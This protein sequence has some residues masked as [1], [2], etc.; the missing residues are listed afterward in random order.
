MLNFNKT[1]MKYKH[2][3]LLSGFLLLCGCGKYLDIVPDGTPTLEHA[4]ADRTR[5]KEFLAT[6]YRYLPDPT[7]C[8]TYPGYAGN[9]FVWN[10][11]QPYDTRFDEQEMTL[12][13]RGRQ[14]SS[15]PYLNFWGGGGGKKVVNLFEGIR[16]CN[17][18]LE[19]IDRPYD[20][21][22]G[23][24]AQWI[25]EV[26]FLKAYYHYFLLQLYGPIPLIKEN[27]PVDS[28]PE[29]VRVF[30]DPF[31]DCVE[32][33][34]QLLDEAA[35]DLPPT[36]GNE[37]EEMGRITSPIAL[38]LKT[39]VLALAASDLFNGNPDFAMCIDKQGR[40]LFPTEKDPDKWKLVAESAKEAIELAESQGNIK[41]YESK[42]ISQMPDQ[43]RLLLTLRGV[44][45]EN[46]NEEII[47]GTT[48]RFD[49]NNKGD[50]MGMGY[51]WY[52]LARECL[53]NLYSYDLQLFLSECGVPM[54]IAEL[55][56]TDKGI[57]IEN[58]PDWIGK[59]VN[60]LMAATAKDKYIIKEGEQ[61]ARFNFNR[62]PR[63][64]A[65]LAFDSSIFQMEV[66]EVPGDPENPVHPYVQ[67]LKGQVSGNSSNR[68][69]NPTGYWAKKLVA[70][71]TSGSYQG[72]GP[73][74][75]QDP[76]AL[77]LI[78]LA[79]LYLL[80]SEALNE[81][82]TTPDDEVY[83]WIDKV[84]ERA[85]LKG[86][87]ESWAMSNVPDKP[88]TQTGMR[89][90]IH[91]ERIIELVFEGQ[92]FFDLRR[93]KW[94]AYTYLNEPIVG[95]SIFGDTKETYYVPTTIFNQRNYSVKDF[96]WPISDYYLT[97]NNNLVQNP[98]WE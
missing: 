93:W 42:P 85:G 83:Y 3:L 8:W 22:A 65:D 81:I 17:I 38:A 48:Q 32:Y 19:N 47:W 31:D 76:Y 97:T 30:R 33:I 23:E 73:T 95:W 43:L 82:K 57:P 39:K 25:G 98:G 21:R 49:T 53:P 27:L 29:E 89:E 28:S 58:D 56:Y 1:T 12:L 60:E 2:I 70:Y 44:V 16:M 84:R 37:L 14:N 68:G 64:Y 78:R 72:N 77:P 51:P 71:G 5:A 74:L 41:L 46:W 10:E 7:D 52:D 91:R 35:A 67:G 86:V 40:H 50:Y 63:F 55:F 45:T 54:H 11:L 26:K 18:F 75:T 59:D 79:D 90:I 62:E 34:V 36:V 13:A 61:T 6:C 87:L 9:E 66:T 94:D 4:F 20:L 92:M 69:T 88:K 80:Y 24:K 96:L 15:S